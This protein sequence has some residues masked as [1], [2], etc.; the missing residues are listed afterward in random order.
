MNPW[1]SAGAAGRP[2]FIGF[3]NG[4]G[5]V[6]VLDHG[7]ETYSVYGLLEDVL[8][9]N[10]E[11]IAKGQVIG[12]AHAEKDTQDYRVYFAVQR[13][14]PHLNQYLKGDSSSWVNR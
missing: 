8:V 2:S 3:V 6:I 12:L 4:L 9:Y 10:L 7:N 11:H 1:V 5:Y 13:K 14:T